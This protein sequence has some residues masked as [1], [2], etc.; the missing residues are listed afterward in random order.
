MPGADKLVSSSLACIT[1]AMCDV[2]MGSRHALG[3]GWATS[4]I[5]RGKPSSSA[6]RS[7][8]GVQWLLKNPDGADGDG[9][10]MPPPYALSE[11]WVIILLVGTPLLG[12]TLPQNSVDWTILADCLF[13]FGTMVLLLLLLELWMDFFRFKYSRK[14]SPSLGECQNA[15]LFQWILFIHH[16][17]H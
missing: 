17:F 15:F 1:G 11:L 8:L 10:T 6:L 4:A 13:F 7:V 16:T 2:V 12:P 9:Q 14:T 5:P 3:G